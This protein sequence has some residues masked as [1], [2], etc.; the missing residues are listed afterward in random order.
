VAG[1]ITD[2]ACE[3]EP[4]RK[5]L[6]RSGRVYRLSAVGFIDTLGAKAFGNDEQ[7]MNAIA[8]MVDV[9]ERVS[10]MTTAPRSIRTTYF[11][12]NIGASVDLQDLDED[13]K[14]DALCRLLRVLAGIQF[15]YLA[16]FGILCRGAVAIGDCFH[17]DNIIFGPALIEAYLLERP[18]DTPRIVVTTPVVD[19]VGDD[20]IPLH[21]PEPLND[22]PG[23][24]YA[25]LRSIDFLRA[26]MPVGES[27]AGQIQR[28]ESTIAAVLASIPPDMPF[29]KKWE[30][31]ADKLNELKTG[32][33]G[34]HS[35]Q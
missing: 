17:S 20:V 8:F 10:K 16:E 27:R 21:P 23:N 15:Y 7:F 18:A 4:V 9:H 2:R 1:D 13:G 34:A 14:K 31:T 11:S 24:V 26:E 22:P 5:Q 3:S 30:W 28:L 29:R 32:E 12:D 19:I 35:V 25:D 6:S 33:C